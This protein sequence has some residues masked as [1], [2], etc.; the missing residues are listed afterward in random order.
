VHPGRTA[1]RAGVPKPAA[2]D[3]RRDTDAVAAENT[4]TAA[5]A[6]CVHADEP[7]GPGRRSRSR[8]DYKRQ[9]QSNH[10]QP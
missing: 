8:G 3:G 5:A 9:Q 7:P 10:N 4:V 6:C 2:T 1:L